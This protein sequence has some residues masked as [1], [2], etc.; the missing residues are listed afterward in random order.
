M[1]LVERVAV[2]MV[3]ANHFLHHKP[4]WAGFSGLGF[5]LW[6]TEV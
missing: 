3:S 4:P 6:L 2:K 1:E 5:P